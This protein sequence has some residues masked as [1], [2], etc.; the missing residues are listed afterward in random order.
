MFANCPPSTRLGREWSLRSYVGMQEKAKVKN[1][2][3]SFSCLCMEIQVNSHLDTDFLLFCAGPSKVFLNICFRGSFLIT[4]PPEENKSSGIQE[5][6]IFLNF[7]KPVDIFYKRL[8]VRV[9]VR[10]FV[11]KDYLKKITKNSETPHFP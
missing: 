10:V 2:S 11:N 9:R 5:L 4:P 3:S 7:R 6:I 8:F 1:P